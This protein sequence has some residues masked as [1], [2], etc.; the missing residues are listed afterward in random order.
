MSSGRA[1]AASSGFTLLEVILAVLVFG[2]SMGGLLMIVQDSLARLGQ[3]RLE[4]EGARL[5]EEQLRELTLA[6]A[7]GEELELGEEAGTYAPPN[8][9]LRWELSVEP[10]WIPLSEELKDRAETSSLFE[11]EETE[12]EASA[13]LR[14][15]L[16]V[17]EEN[18]EEQLVDP[19]VVFLVLPPDEA[20]L[21]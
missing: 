4:S 19:F 21:P 10:W 6:A 1:R 9:M 2:I 14:L 5:A 15:T 12:F 18:H 20:D 7:T 11:P 3:A 13:L 16:R 8:D 17:F